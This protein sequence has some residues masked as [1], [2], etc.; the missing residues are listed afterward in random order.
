L[1]LFSFLRFGPKDSDAGQHSGQPVV[2]AVF[3]PTGSGKSSFLS[4]LAG[5]SHGFK[6]GTNLR[7]E[8]SEIEIKTITIRGRLV[9]LIDT[10]G[11]N[12]TTRPDTQIL[13]EVAAFLVASASS[14]TGLKLNGLLYFHRITDNRVGGVEFSN[15]VMFEKLCG[16]EGL[17]NVILCTTMWDLVKK[18]DGEAREAQLKAEFWQSMIQ[19]NANA[20]RHSGTR[21]SARK[22]VEELVPKPKAEVQL[23]KELGIMA[24]PATSA[25]REVYL[26]VSRAHE[27][28]V[29]HIKLL[30]QHADTARGPLRDKLAL[31]LEKQVKKAEDLKRQEKDFTL[32]PEL[33]E[34]VDV[35]KAQ[36]RAFK[37]EHRIK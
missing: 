27:R 30:R 3:G 2:I 14:D 31:E 21:A 16:E 1:G 20:R 18:K 34:Q 13:E 10:P 35:A 6:V 8:T 29:E 17:R 28:A 15:M 24:L 36:I 11:F 4:R 5:D 22:I 26:S 19:N 12:D 32:H 37:A 23:Q 33:K 7:S 25:G 9:I